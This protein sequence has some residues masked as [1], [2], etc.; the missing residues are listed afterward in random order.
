MQVG[1]HFPWSRC[2][3]GG[4]DSG[5]RARRQLPLLGLLCLVAYWGTLQ[6]PTIFFDNQ[7]LLSPCL[8]VFALLQFGWLGLPVGVMAAAA[9]VQLWGHPWAAVPMLLQLLWQQLFLQHC[10]GGPDQRGNGRI[11]LATIVYWLLLG[12]PLKIF[13]YTG[14]LPV[15]LQ[16]AMA[17]AFKEGVVGVVDAGL[18]LLLYLGLQLYDLRRRTQR[19]RDLSLRGLI[20]AT[21]LLMISLPGVLIIMAMGQQLTLQTIIQ[22]RLNLQQQAGAIAYVLPEGTR[23]IPAERSI[24]ERLQGLAFEAVA[25]DGHRFSSDPKLFSSLRRDYTS[26]RNELL[27][28]NGL[29]L[30]IR[31]SERAVLQRHLDG[32]WQLQQDLPAAQSSGWRRVTVVQPARQQMAMLLGMM[33]PA[34]QI[35]GLLLI[36]AALISEV[37]TSL[38]GAQF[39]RMLGS[40]TLLA[41][42][43]TDPEQV[44]MPEL[45]RTRIRELNRIVALINQQVGIVNQ[46]SLNL[47]QSHARLLQ[48]EQ[49]HRLLADNALDVITICDPS[50]R[51]TYISPSISRVRGWSVAEA[52]AMPMESHLKEEGC[53]FVKAA[54]RQTL[55][56]VDD[57]LPLPDFRVELEQSHRDGSWIWTDVTSTCICDEQGSYVGTLLVYRDISERKRLENEL[58]QRASVDDL[59]GLLNRRELLVRLDGLL[60]ASNRR[61]RGEEIALLF[62]DLDLF[63]QIND[64]HGHAAGDGVLRIVAERTRDCLRTDDIA[65]RVGGDEIV[66]VLQ[67][68]ADLQAAQKLA[69]TIVGAI[70]EPIHLA[71]LEVTVTASMGVSLA[72]SG[73]D[74]NALLAR[75]DSAMYR[76]KQSGGRSVVA[77]A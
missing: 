77:L 40:L 38:L 8:A 59:T 64:C 35:L 58:L 15:D 76:A 70:A 65:A 1:D 4:M 66:V 63:K 51:P 48:S 25:A 46:L 17:L 34:L 31:G 74:G 50:G 37:L 69:E 23:A 28:S 33:R 22:F 60:Q 5:A 20:F 62:F 44:S 11:V 7:I 75:A 12:L 47:R 61:R 30:L 27:T 36:A 29:T 10:N 13:L 3:M 19:R 42:A 71:A 9:T 21:L 39:E 68:V 14:L 73:E 54:L 49:R 16:S 43:G 72:R 56:A 18:G 2:R 41:P 24:S 57:G 6:S 26:D 52:M 45:Q 55:E 67:G 32:Y 53:A